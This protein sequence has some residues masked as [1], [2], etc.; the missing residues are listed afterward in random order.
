MENDL[1]SKLTPAAQS[2]LDE[3]VNEYRDEI[4]LAAAVR[5]AQPTGEL[6]DISVRDIVSAAR[7]RLRS[8]RTRQRATLERLLAVY[9]VTG[10][11]AATVGLGIFSVDQFLRDSDPAVRIPL[12]VGLIGAIL[13]VGS[14]SL[15]YLRKFGVVSF[16][17]RLADAS[18]GELIGQYLATWRDVEVALRNMAASSLG[19]T[20]AKEPISFSVERLQKHDELSSRDA[21]VIQQ[22]LKERNRVVHSPDYFQEEAVLNSLRRAQNVLGRIQHQASAA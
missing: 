16:P 21:E 18:G 11:L 4:L 22:L 3:I 19:E 10:A 2:A 12:F 1:S 9:A 7:S 15:M 20:V 5:A 13:A 6:R 17:N 8:K 14:T